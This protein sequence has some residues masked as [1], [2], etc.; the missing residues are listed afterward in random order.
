MLRRGLAGIAIMMLAGC[1][2][3]NTGMGNIQM[4]G[5]TL[6]LP[7]DYRATVAHAVA[8]AP[9]QA[10]RQLSISQPQT[11]AGKTAIDPKRWYVCVDG[12]QAP[13]PAAGAST[14]GRYDTIVILQQTGLPDVLH[15]Y[16]AEL[17]A[18]VSFAPL[19]S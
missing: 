2:T 3:V 1:D 19:S 14:S 5:D 13:A 6:P 11:L 15:A 16:G 17:C 9:V 12:L 4:S 10:G 8:G 18:G 7:K